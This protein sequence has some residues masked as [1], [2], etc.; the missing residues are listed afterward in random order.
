VKKHL[1]IIAL[2]LLAAVFLRFFRLGQIPVSMTDDEVRLVYS[3]YS[4][5]NTGKD[6]N[7]IFL[8]L[9][10]VIDNYAFNPVAIY[11]TS[12]LVGIFG[13]S[14]F[15]SRLPF[16]IVGSLSILVTYLISN[17]LFK[18]KIISILSIL[19][20]TFSAWHLQL[21]RFAY[22]GGFALLLFLLGIY[23]FILVEKDKYKMLYLSLFI[24]LLA[25]NSY[26]GTKLILIPVMFILVWYKYKDLIK[27]QIIITILSVIVIFF[28]FFL[29]S[30]FQN[31]ASYG[32]QQFFFQDNATKA[33]SVELERRA[34]FTPKYIE[35]LYHNK[36]TYWSGIFLNHY[37]RAFSPEYLFTS[38]EGNGIFAM[39]Y[40]GQL[41]LVELPLILLGL[42]YLFK[43]KR[44]EFILLVSFLIVAPLPSGLGANPITYTVRSSFMLPWLMI[45][46]GSGIYSISFFIKSLKLKILL[47]VMLLAV[48]T[49]SIG[50]YLNQYYYEWM[51]YGS[52]YYSK[53]TQDL[54]FLVGEKKKE[55]SQIIV[56]GAEKNIFLHYTFYNSMDPKIVQKKLKENVIRTENISF[57]RECIGSNVD[58]TKSFTKR[59]TLLIA[60][61]SCYQKSIPDYYI[62]A[63]DHSENM[64]KIYVGKDN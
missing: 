34:S 15:V 48:Y 33:Q 46:I 53:T 2:I 44:K 24:F 5:W 7:G 58:G 21:S 54:V 14:M 16:A 1:L 17:R 32:G 37:L 40:R 23:T 50:G 42:F 49:Y 43:N 20:F 52:K 26:S 30:K 45:L 38:Q 3:A 27:K 51:S 31:A 41:Y 59:N 61:V 11:L 57:A 55:Y 18:N 39:W 13:L 22:E 8:P 9:A 25:F 36:F 10:F 64:W 4:I 6:L 19:V 62:S 47:Y 12:P 56:V 63:S 35:E 60:S 28:L 29:L